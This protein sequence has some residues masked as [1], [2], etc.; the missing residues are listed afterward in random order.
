MHFP[1]S[2]RLRKRCHS[3]YNRSLSC[4]GQR[5]FQAATLNI[6][7]SRATLSRAVTS[8]QAQRLLVQRFGT[9]RFCISC[10]RAQRFR[11]RRFRADRF[12]AHR[13]RAQ[14]FRGALSP[15]VLSPAVLLPVAFL[16]ATFSDVEVS[17]ATLSRAVFS[18]PVILRPS[19]A[20][21]DA[22]D[23]IRIV[24]I[25]FSILISAF[26]NVTHFFQ[27]ANFFRIVSLFFFNFID[28]NWK[29]GGTGLKFC[30][31]ILGDTIF[32]IFEILFYFENVDFFK[33]SRI[34][35]R[36][37]SEISNIEILYIKFQS[38]C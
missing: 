10:S 22:L 35:G 8:W 7:L 28:F 24:T 36:N 26:Q 12:H 30:S 1:C 21:F 27:F 2:Y 5:F 13:F 17:Y 9:Q 16:H 34:F 3:L 15:A 18:R 11:V 4:H 14:G 23:F 38:F 29:Y 37:C 31:R 20:I 6:S 25:L 32:S 19:R 33:S